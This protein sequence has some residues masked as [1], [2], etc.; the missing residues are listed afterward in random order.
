[1]QS[2]LHFLNF[3]SSPLLLAIFQLFIVKVTKAGSKIT[4]SHIL[5]AKLF[6]LNKFLL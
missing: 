3:F 5:E 1:M 6:T 2:T 4:R